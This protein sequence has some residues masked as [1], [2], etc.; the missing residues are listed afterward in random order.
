MKPGDCPLEPEIVAAAH[1]GRWTAELRSHVQHCAECAD[2][3][4]VAEVVRHSAQSEANL[5]SAGQVWWRAQIRARQKDA[6]RAVQ[7]VRL[8]QKI[9]AALAVVGLIFLLLRYASHLQ[10]WWMRL[11]SE[12][13]SVEQSLAWVFLGT[14]A[15]V[16]AVVSAG[17]GYM[18][19]SSK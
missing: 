19:R 6:E 8:V 4:M 3:V 15:M 16:V 11:P 12:A 2:T 14:A 5:P 9:T 1:L 18:R 7:P 10:Q 17:V 13:A